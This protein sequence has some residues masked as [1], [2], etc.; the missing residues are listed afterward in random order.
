MNEGGLWLCAGLCF[1]S[2]YPAVRRKNFLFPCRFRIQV[3][4]LSAD[5][6]NAGYV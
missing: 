1:C 3:D 2:S 6:A 5:C 4:Q